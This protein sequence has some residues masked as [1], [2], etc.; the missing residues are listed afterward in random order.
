[1]LQD[2][3]AWK[4]IR[5]AA[6]PTSRKKKALLLFS[7]SWRRTSDSSPPDLPLQCMVGVKSIVTAVSGVMKAE[8]D[9]PITISFFYAYKIGGNSE[10]AP[11]S[12]GTSYWRRLWD[13][14]SQRSQ[15]MA[16]G[17]SGKYAFAGQVNGFI[18]LGNVSLLHFCLL[19]RL[20][21]NKLLCQ[22][23]WQYSILW[24]IIIYLMLH[25]FQNLFQSEF[26]LQIL[27]TS[28]CYTKYLAF[29]PAHLFQHLLTKFWFIFTPST[30]PWIHRPFL[31]ATCYKRNRSTN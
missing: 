5:T 8:H 20:P 14:F 7:L 18:L 23:I 24:Y 29:W 15:E 28:F 30:V 19:C 10:W 22:E 4:L 25:Q 6:W 12:N 1:M 31:L 9:K 3:T 27:L 2:I 13:P 21:A 26:S 17:Q 16:D 11:F